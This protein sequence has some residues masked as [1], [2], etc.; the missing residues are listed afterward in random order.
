[1]LAEGEPAQLL[2]H[3]RVNRHHGA[4]GGQAQGPLGLGLAGLQQPLG[5]SCRHGLGVRQC[6]Q[7]HAQGLA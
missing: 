2:P 5:R 1:L 4:P 7:F 3:R 6:K